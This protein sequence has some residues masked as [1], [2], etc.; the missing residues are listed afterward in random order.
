MLGCEEPA[1]ESGRY[2]EKKKP[3][4][5]ADSALRYRGAGRVS[6]LLAGVGAGLDWEGGGAGVEMQGGAG[7]LGGFV[8]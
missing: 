4:G 1:S 5:S 8:A 2:K 6:V 3:Q 7:D